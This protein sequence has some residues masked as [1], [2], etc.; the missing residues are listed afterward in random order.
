MTSFSVYCTEFHNGRVETWSEKETIA[1]GPCTSPPT[2]EVCSKNISV[3]TCSSIE[4]AG[5][6][7]KKIKNMMI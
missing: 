7:K 4:I 6:L 3:S 2:L 1:W 5:L